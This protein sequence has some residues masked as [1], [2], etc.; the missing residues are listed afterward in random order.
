M[1]MYM[2]MWVY[3]PLHEGKKKAERYKDLPNSHCRISSF[4]SLE[5]VLCHKSLG[6]TNSM[7]A[8][9]FV[10]LILQLKLIGWQTKGQKQLQLV[11][12]IISS[13]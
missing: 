1:G 12:L 8:G 10:I 3:V 13:I 7:T 2:H 4:K 5:T 6:F 9:C 11:L